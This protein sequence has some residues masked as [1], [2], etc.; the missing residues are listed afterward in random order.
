MDL[1]LRAAALRLGRSE[2]TLRDQLVRGVVPGRKKQGRWVVREEDLPLDENRRVEQRRRADAVRATV[3]SAIARRQPPMTIEDVELFRLGRVLLH[4]LPPAQSQAA[5]ELRTG[6]VHL[7][8]AHHQFE[9]EHKAT[10]LRRAR[11][12]LARATGLL[13]LAAPVEGEDPAALAD[14]IEREL[15]PRLG[16]FIRRASE[17]PA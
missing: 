6:L 11:V 1:D 3:E 5:E 9:N 13:R 4:R 8:V 16:G 10:E 17:K 15:L 14:E 7:T 12:C 2:R